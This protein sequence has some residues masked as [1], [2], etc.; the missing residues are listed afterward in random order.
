MYRVRVDFTLRPG[1]AALTREEEVA[2][3]ERAAAAVR[4]IIGG[5][6]V[7][8]DYDTDVMGDRE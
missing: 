2:L 8:D 4:E 6:V 5:H 7:I 3:A 1:E